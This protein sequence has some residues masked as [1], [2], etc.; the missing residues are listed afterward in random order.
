MAFL[1]STFITHGCAWCYGE[2]CCVSLLSWVTY[3]IDDQSAEY[4][5][6]LLF[7]LGKPVKLSFFSITKLVFNV[8]DSCVMIGQITLRIQPII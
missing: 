5:T 6:L 2:S 7:L 1:V 3:F 4:N 8:N